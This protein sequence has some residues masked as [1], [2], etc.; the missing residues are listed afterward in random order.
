VDVATVYEKLLPESVGGKLARRLAAVETS[1]SGFIILLG[2][3]KTFPDLAHHTLFFS[4]DYQREFDDIFRRGIPPDEPTIYA[5]ITSKTDPDH[6]PPGCENWFILVNAPPLSDAFDWAR[7][8]EHYRNRVLDVLEQR[9]VMLR[10]AIRAERRLTPVDLERLSGARRGALYG[11]SS[12]DRFNALRRPHNRARD[13]RGLYFAGG[14]THPGG[15]VPMVT[16]SGAA[17]AR[18]VM[19]DFAR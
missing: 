6:A 16:L 14:T 12:N 9:G 1:C 19:Q 4:S 18:M 11:T 13:V 17:A 5:A 3:A 10:D 7:E 15:G 8:S 2:V